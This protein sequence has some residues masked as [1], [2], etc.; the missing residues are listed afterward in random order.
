[1]VS[2]D[3]PYVI[4]AGRTLSEACVALD[5]LEKS[6]EVNLKA[7]VIGGRKPLGAVDCRL[8]RAVYRRKYSR[9][10]LEHEQIGKV[11]SEHGVGPENDG[12]TPPWKEAAEALVKYG[13]MLA[14]SKPFADEK[15]LIT[16][17]DLG[18]ET[19]RRGDSAQ[20][21]LRV[22][23]EHLLIICIAGNSLCVPGRLLCKK[24][25]DVFRCHIAGGHKFQAVVIHG[26]H[27]V[28]RNAAAT[29]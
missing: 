26:L 14:E 1:M 3:D 20:L 22:L 7:S 4:T 5:I 10:S 21:D 16:E 29:D 8:M 18:M 15:T 11:A 23:G 2:G 17:I 28:H 27:M 9:P 6:A 19:G 24:D 12:S 25:I 13:R